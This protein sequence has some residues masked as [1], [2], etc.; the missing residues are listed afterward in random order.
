M[1]FDSNHYVPCLRWKQGEYQALM[2]SS[3]GIKDFITPLI[4]VPE[5]GFDFETNSES[6][7]I[8]DHLSK[9]AKRV[10]EKW[11][12]RPCF[13]DVHLFESSKLM[14]SG[15][16][17]IEFIFDDLRLKGALAIPV[18][19]L[20]QDSNCQKAI[21]SIVGKDKRGLC[22]RIS[23]EESAKSNLGALL[24][25]LINTY[26]VKVS[27]CDL[28]LDEG[29]PNFEPIDGFEKLLVTLIG[30]LPYIDKWRSFGLIGTS[31][32][33]SMGEVKSGSSI[34]PRN[35]WRLYK[36]LIRRL[37]SSGIRIPTFGDYVINHPDI[38]VV[39]MRLAKPSATVRYTIDDGWL[40]VKGSNVRDN[41]YDQYRRLCKTVVE[42][43]HYSGPT[44]SRGDKYIHDCAQGTES[45]G[46]LTTWRW[47]GTNH[48]LEKV[49]QDV[50]NLSFS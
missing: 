13:V 41:G 29:A 42:S 50:A 31:F 4:E 11:G 6:K 38:I 39:N 10:K 26:N 18:V 22:I 43:G 23:I 16:H 44:F 21:K 34:I 17:P 27:D 19:D 32:P 36:S 12:D 7:S 47:V 35:E 14:M 20:K 40:I 25:G 49:V 28:I 1:T 37:M 5:I 15:Q 33:R 8:D 30:K 46:R 3:S 24:D 2:R 45:T 48:H 9:F